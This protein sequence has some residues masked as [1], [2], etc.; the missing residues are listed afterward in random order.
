MVAVVR[1]EHPDPAFP[2]LHGRPARGWVNDPNGCSYVDGCY[3][4]FFQHNPE[5]PV[6]ETIKWGHIS[7]TDLVHWQPEP[8][9]LVNRPGELDAY[10]CWSGCGVDDTGVPIAVY[11]GVVDDGG[12]SQVLL[13]R[14]DRRMQI[15]VA[16]QGSVT[17]MPDDPAITDV[18]D[19]F[20]FE[21]A[22]HRY[23]VQGAG[24]RHGQ[25][26]LL[27]YGCDD[28][29]AWVPLGALL[30]AADP[31]AATA[32]PANIWECPNLMRVDG[33]WVLLV[34]LWRQVG[35]G[36]SLDGV[37]W[38]IGDLADTVAGPRFTPVA[39]GEL[40]SGPSFYAPQVLTL[41][42]RV[43][44]W[45]WSREDG[46]SAADVKAAGWAGMLTFV[47]ELSVADG[48]LVSQPAP[49][50]R[51]LRR[52]GLEV[53]AGEPFE[54]AAFELDLADGAG[55]MSLWLIEHADPGD[56]VLVAEWQL[57][58]TPLVEPRVLV[59]GSIVEIFD[60][61]AVARTVRAYPTASSRWVVRTTGGFPVRG[62]LLGSAPG[63]V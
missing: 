6:H 13:A 18:R 30:T 26:Q 47:R 23:A 15:W 27:V 14:S 51:L 8:I 50:L 22:G 3:H 42:D 11:S 9:A 38:F 43:L 45:G 10:G 4:V 63:S 16:E 58:A 31:L 7:S 24:H 52:A 56:E 29:R 32:A 53:T 57:A 40:D 55:P 28:L 37:R 59:D 21:L 41:D 61:G 46:C 39:A 62:W 1:R 19:P 25:P 44:L 36:F 35:G 49:E 5:R 54:A 12:R 17:G 34:S 33:R 48:A 2:G 60:G 20:V